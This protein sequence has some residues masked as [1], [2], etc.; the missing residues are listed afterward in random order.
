MDAPPPERSPGRER[1]GPR[2]EPRGGQGRESAPGRAGRA[3]RQVR[4]RR[5]TPARAWRSGCAA[6]PGAR[7]E[8]R[9]SRSGY[10]VRRARARPTTSATATTAKDDP[11]HKAASAWAGAGAAALGLDGEVDAD[12]FRTVLEGKVPDGS[13]TQLGRRG[14]E[15][16]IEHRPGRDLTFSAPKSVSLAALVGGDETHRRR[17]R[18]GRGGNPR[19][20]GE[21]R[22]RDPDAGPGD[23]TDGPGRESE[24]RRRHLPPRHLAQPRPAAPHPCGARQLGA[25]GGRQVAEH[26][27]RGAL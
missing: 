16:S 5:R 13:G 9:C 6:L 7:L 22:R 11:E 12:V 8:L 24:D 14:K 18:P 4:G 10:S 17:P 23:R 15:G 21:E 27:Q 19:L 2:E 1:C 3:F 20:G 25:G 26:G